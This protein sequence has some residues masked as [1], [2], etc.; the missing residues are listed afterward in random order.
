MPSGARIFSKF[1]FDAKTY[2]AVI[3]T[4]THFNNNNN[5]NNN[6]NNNIW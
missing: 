3:S 1:P 2:H 6:N 4:K 5:K